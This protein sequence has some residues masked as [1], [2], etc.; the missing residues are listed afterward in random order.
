[1]CVI[2]WGQYKILNLLKKNVDLRLSVS[3]INDAISKF[4]N[5]SF[6]QTGSMRFH[7]RTPWNFLW[8]KNNQNIEYFNLT[9]WLI[10]GFNLFPMYQE[11]FCSITLKTYLFLTNKLC[12]IS[13]NYLEL[14]SIYFLFSLSILDFWNSK[15]SFNA[16]VLS[17]M[18]TDGSQYDVYKKFQLNHFILM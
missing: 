8:R 17:C 18:C 14:S 1:M 7:T 12:E 5:K 11:L 3:F 10:L 9:C 4:I 6:L 2:L 16:T 15:T 13:K